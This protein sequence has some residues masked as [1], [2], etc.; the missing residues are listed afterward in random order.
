[1]FL[2]FLNKKLKVIIYIMILS[3]IL[4]TIICNAIPASNIPKNKNIVNLP[5]RKSIKIEKTIIAAKTAEINIFTVILKSISF[6]F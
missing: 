2:K 6:Y 5:T 4:V 3:Y 1:M